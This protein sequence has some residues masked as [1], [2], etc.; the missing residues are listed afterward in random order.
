MNETPI[1]HRSM[2]GWN[3]LYAFEFAAI[4]KSG[5]RT[6]ELRVRVNWLRHSSSNIINQYQ[7]TKVV[8]ERDFRFVDHKNIKWNLG[9]VLLSEGTKLWQRYNF[10]GNGLKSL[11]FFTFP[12][13]SM[14][15][16]IWFSIFKSTM[17]SNTSF[18]TRKIMKK[19]LGC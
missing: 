11:P 13:S 2:V 7:C 12:L 14:Y 15:T 16:T 18:A 8:L 5:C 4:L 10:I 1:E 19:K 3:S 6:V 17:C 9:L